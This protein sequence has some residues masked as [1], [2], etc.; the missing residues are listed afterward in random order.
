MGTHSK[1]RNH[2]QENKTL[3]I[4][5]AVGLFLVELEIF[6]MASMGSGRKSIVQVLDQ[7]SSVIYEVK[8][9]K[10]SSHEKTEFEKTFGPLSNYRVNVVTQ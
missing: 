5:L 3:F 4:I 2:F 10:L 1:W 8:S 7:Q 9:A 6:A